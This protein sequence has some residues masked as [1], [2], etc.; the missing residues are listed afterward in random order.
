MEDPEK[1][2]AILVNLLKPD[3]IM[4]I[5]LYSSTARSTINAARAAI[6]KGN[7]PPTP[8]GMRKFRK[9]SPKLLGKKH[10]RALLHAT[11]YYSL[12][13]YRDL[14]FH[15]HEDQFEISRIKTDLKNMGLIFDGFRVSEDVMTRFREKFPDDPDGL[16]LDNWQIFEQN[17]PDTF[18][19]C[20]GFWCYKSQD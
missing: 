20:Y 6:A 10:M 11:D 18:L 7:Y 5:G 16:D 14:L 8:E 9:D 3:G 15:V 17:H 1:G 13:M 4:Y 19:A 2:W 12:N